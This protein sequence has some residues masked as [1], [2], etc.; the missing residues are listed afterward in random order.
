MGLVAILAGGLTLIGASTYLITTRLLRKKRSRR[1][2]YEHLYDDDEVD[3]FSDE[4]D[5]D[6]RMSE[7]RRKKG[8]RRPVAERPPPLITFA[9][10]YEQAVALQQQRLAQRNVKIY[11]DANDEYVREE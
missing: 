11:F 3:Y 1:H 5:L 9:E 8:K 10:L 6:Y 7:A 4:E 2:Q